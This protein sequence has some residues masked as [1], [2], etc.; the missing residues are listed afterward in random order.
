[1]TLAQHPRHQAALKCL[2]EH[3]PASYLDLEYRLNTTGMHR[4][5]AYLKQ[6]NFVASIKKSTRLELQRYEITDLGRKAIGLL[7]AEKPAVHV[8][9]LSDR[10]M[11]VTA[12]DTPARAGAM[13]AY[14]IQSLGGRTPAHL[15][16]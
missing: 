2:A 1:M 15:A 16:R 5:T 8:P 4:V 10:P 9:R 13:A 7:V 3:G 6:N 11:L 14:K 12:P